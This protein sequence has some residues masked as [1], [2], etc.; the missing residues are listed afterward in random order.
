MLRTNLLISLLLFP[1]LLLADEPAWDFVER[2]L[3]T[4]QTS[5]VDELP[6][7][8]WFAIEPKLDRLRQAQTFKLRLPGGHEFAADVHTAQE[9]S[10][11]DTTL[12]LH[13]ERG[14]H[15][16]LT[17]GPNG[18]FG[19]VSSPQ[20]LFQILTDASGSWMIHLDDPRLAVDTSCGVTEH[21]ELDAPVPPP[22]SLA[23]R[24]SIEQIDVILLYSPE[25]SQRYPGSL[26]N[27]RLNHL[28]ALANQA[29]VDSAVDI[30]FRK[31]HQAEVP[32][33]DSP[34]IFD[35]LDGMRLGLSG[36]DAGVFSGL[37]QLRAAHGADLVVFVW[38]HDIETRGACGV[39]YLPQFD[40]LSG[41]YDPSLGVHVTNDGISNW[42][43]CSDHV[44]AHEF[45]HNLGASHQ[46]YPGVTGYNYAH[47]IPEVLNTIMGSFSSSDRNRYLRMGVYS[48]PDIQCGGLPCGSMAPGEET[49][50]AQAMNDYAG[51]VAGY[52]E[53][54]HPGTQTRPAPSFPD[55][56]GDGQD[57]WTDPY[58]FDPHNGNPPPTPEPPAFVAPPLMDGSEIDHFEL[59]V[60]SS[61]SDQVHAWRMNGRWRGPVIQAEPL[62]F[63]DK[64]PALSEFTRMLVRDD[65]LVYMLSSASV[66]RFDRV[67]GLELDNYLDSQPPFMPP[68]SLIDGFPRSMSFSPDQQQLLVLGEDNVQVYND[69]AS[70]V[71][72]RYGLPDVDD[73]SEPQ[74]PVRMRAAAFDGSG[75]HYIVDQAAARIA[76][77]TGYEPADYGGELVPP[78][79][80]ALTDPRSMVFGPDG[81][82]Y[83]ANGQASNVLR[84]PPAGGS[85]EVFVSAGSGGLNF[86]RDLAFGPDGNLY[87][88]SRNNN[89]V[90]RYDGNTGAF[91]NAFIRA[92]SAGLD[93]PESLIFTRRIDSEI[94]D[95]RFETP[96]V[97]S[98]E[99]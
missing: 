24:G 65:G 66:R 17:V 63:P 34:D 80:A 11:A 54:V 33:P 40:D 19:Q 28:L 86:A 50:V 89:A 83:I 47:V 93:K 7:G 8:S 32:T 16:H 45:G 3:A 52:A 84:V 60:A 48:N 30:V 29:T 62:P 15:A 42:S 78:G 38:P 70:P 69:L 22:D 55:S 67:S 13:G 64:R 49:N 1:M 98:A 37:D 81:G 94:F 43:V 87:V 73:P 68:G 31:V 88:I 85:I 91:V 35:A 97:H 27:T 12:H 44:M 26:L 59:L 82:L 77:Y 90:L 56:D 61:G 72:I 10:N 14:G 39:A 4:R 41:Q 95:D 76:V 74:L 53:P 25:I 21:A 57:D 51:I 23:E 58:P 71:R 20:G 96:A 99:P 92:G 18:L 46:R 75:N 9:Q 6:P 5:M 2:P 36:E 79:A